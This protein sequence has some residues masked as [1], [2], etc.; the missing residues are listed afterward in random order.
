MI[1]IL[2]LRILIWAAIAIGVGII[3]DGIGSILIKQGQY[4][5]IYFDG[6]RYVRAVAGAIMLILGVLAVVL[7]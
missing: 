1:A 4:H 3:A 2:I 6:E 7:T 5:N